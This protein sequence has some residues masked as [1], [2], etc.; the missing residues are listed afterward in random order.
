MAKMTP[1]QQR[2]VE[3]YLVDLNALQAAIRA[4][5]S[6]K[7]A[8]QQGPRLLGNAGVQKAIQTAMQERSER[9][10]V[11]MDEV[12]REFLRVGLSDMRN[13]MVWGPDGMTLLPS[14]QLSDDVAAAVS[15]VSQTITKDGGTIRLKLHSK[16]D[17]LDKLARHLGLYAPDK[18][19]MTDSEGRD[20]GRDPKEE[21]RLRLTQIV[22][23]TIAG[24]EVLSD[25]RG[26]GGN[27]GGRG[28]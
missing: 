16:M 19:A 2:F 27:D 20:I 28:G 21:F 25:L 17:A 11:D 8:E 14:D 10:Q 24:R 9:V 26:T 7:T 6:K 23:R 15:E 4:G 5:Y 22:E 3:E 1:K 12:I 18:V 13:V